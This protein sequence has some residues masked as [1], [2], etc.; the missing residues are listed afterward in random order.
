ML[1]AIGK[2]FLLS[3]LSKLEAKKVLNVNVLDSVYL[4][5][6]KMNL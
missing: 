1:T 4:L 5:H 3:A 2:Y 6:D